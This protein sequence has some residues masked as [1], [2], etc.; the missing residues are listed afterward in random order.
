VPDGGLLPSVRTTG[1]QRR[2]YEVDSC[3][4]K[5]IRVAQRVGLSVAE[6]RALLAGLPD[7]SDITV[8][9]WHRLRHRLEDEVRVRIDALTAALDDLTTEDK[10]CEVPPSTAPAGAREDTPQDRR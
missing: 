7:R 4:V 6:I 5:V 1:N 3:L 10:L 2:F 8:D 9:D